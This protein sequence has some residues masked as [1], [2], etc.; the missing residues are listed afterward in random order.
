MLTYDAFLAQAPW[1]VGRQTEYLRCQNR[2][3]WVLITPEEQVRQYAL[4]ILHS[5]GHPASH[6]AVERSFEHL[7]RLKRL[8]ILSYDANMTPF[9]LIECKR[10]DLNVA[11]ADLMQLLEYNARWQVPYLALFN[12]YRCFCLHRVSEK[13]LQRLDQLPAYPS[14]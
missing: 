2:K 10:S 14:S 11:E 7:S 9:L 3:K 13:E 5:L 6:I 12:G 1:R 8:D 4:Y